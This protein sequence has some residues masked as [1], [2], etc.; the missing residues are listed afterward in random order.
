VSVARRVQTERVFHS[1]DWPLFLA[2]TASHVA[3]LVVVV[4]FIVDA[5]AGSPF[6]VPAV[7]LLPAGALLLW[8]LR[9]LGLP[10]MRKPIATPA[11]AGWRVGVATTFVPA[12]EPVE[13][14][15]QTVEALV[16]MDYE[17][18]TWVLDEGDDPLVKELCDRLGAKH[19]SRRDRAELN[20]DSG[21]Y[22]RATKYGNYNAW[23][24][25][26][27]FDRYDVVVSVDPDHV[28]KPSYLSDVLA[29]F[30]DPDVAYV[31][32][33]QVYYNQPASLVA[34]GAA[35][36]TYA[37]YSSVQCAYFALG[38]P[39]VVGC[40][41]AH[42]VDALREI[43]GFP[44]H[45]ADDLLMT[46]RYRAARWR[47]VYVPKELAAGLVPVDWPAYLRQQRRWARST[48]DIK[49]RQRRYLDSPLPPIDRVIAG[50][51]GLYYLYPLV[52][53]LSL[54]LLVWLLV[55]DR[56]VAV[57]S[58]GGV[59]RFSLLSATVL[60]CELF[61]QRFYINPRREFGIHWRAALLRLA[62]WPHLMLAL[63]DVIFGVRGGY[64]VTPKLRRSWRP[65][66]SVV[67]HLLV[68][69]IVAGAWLASLRN[70]HPPLVVQLLAV[71]TLAA[72]LVIALTALVRPPPPF[73]PAL[74]ER[75]FSTASGFRRARRK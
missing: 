13:M 19:F 65:F 46:L 12:A 66:Q 60:P 63:L 21:P 30:D 3:A 40:H 49:L 50:V 47:G 14:L 28:P 20:T 52:T 26:I 24:H 64:V 34:R 1:W 57:F 53:A 37:Y 68:M 61:R 7:V 43:G 72:L 38:H 35:E 70:E 29:Y 36:E 25:A 2:L 55:T 27:G 33:A 22:A 62:K 31:Q 42:R 4:R 15:E 6:L 54:A 41:N 39:I 17:H 18:E 9:W 67:P 74:A 71:I 48:L 45:E 59:A 23:L 51:H 32:G 44:A 75:Y 8:E 16:G 69:A 73:D 11:S 56:H 5:A 10:M 58:L